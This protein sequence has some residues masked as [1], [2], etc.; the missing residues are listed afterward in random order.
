MYLIIFNLAVNTPY[1]IYSIY[2]K[3]N[4]YPKICIN[5]LNPCFPQ[6]NNNKKK[7]ID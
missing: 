5:Y 1:I 3:L 7:F 4:N 2:Y 6:I